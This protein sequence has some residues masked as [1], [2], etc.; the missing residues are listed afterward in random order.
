M[1]NSYK[2]LKVWQKSIDLVEEV[3]ILTGDFPKDET[4]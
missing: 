2:E 1:L 4:Y 3:Y